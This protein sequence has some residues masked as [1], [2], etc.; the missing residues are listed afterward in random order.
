VTR[1]AISRS[2]GTHPKDSPVQLALRR[3]CRTIVPLLAFYG[4]CLSGVSWPEEGPCDSQLVPPVGD[5]NAYR[6]RGDRCEGIY[7]KEVA[8]SA[9][10]LIASFTEAFENYN[11]ASG[12][13][14][15]IDWKAP[16]GGDVRLRAYALRRRLYYRMDTLRPTGSTSYVWPPSLLAALNIAKRDLGVVGWLSYPL[17][18]T[19][20]EV[21]VPL[22]IRP[23][24]MTARSRSYQLILLPG[25]ELTEVFISLAHVAADGRPDRSIKRDAPLSYGYYPA[26]RGITIPIPELPVPG[27]YSMEIGATLRE[28]GSSTMRFW[29]YHAGR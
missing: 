22:T 24:G 15:I 9:N 11:A 13:D 16:D 4:V 25:V 5:P 6:V 18:N 10:L 12:T 8:G 1:A 7:I 14:L 28:S 2:A 27:I 19:K 29:F 20:R 23:R 21:F 26:E 3:A 17:G